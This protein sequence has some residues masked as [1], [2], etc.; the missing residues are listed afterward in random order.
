MQIR[1]QEGGKAYCKM[2][3]ISFTSGGTAASRSS[4]LVAMG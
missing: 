3:V 4:G 1:D 2:A